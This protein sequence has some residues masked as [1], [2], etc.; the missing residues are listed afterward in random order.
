MTMPQAEKGGLSL[1]SHRKRWVIVCSGALS[2]Y[3]KRH[4]PIF[5][6]TFLNT[7]G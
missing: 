6:C 4:S 7:L 5:M 3:Y 1:I 2:V